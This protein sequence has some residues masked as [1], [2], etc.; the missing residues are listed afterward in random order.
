MQRPTLETER[1]VLRPFVLADAPRVQHL[2]GDRAVAEFTLNIPHPYP[3]GAAEK[4]IASHQPK[5]EKGELVNFAIT[6]RSDGELIGAVGLTLVSAHLRAEIGYWIGKPYWGQGY[7]TEAARAVVRYGFDVLKLNRIQ[8]RHFVG[9]PASGR[10]M[11]K[12]GMIREGCLRQYVRKWGQFVDMVLYGL[13]RSDHHA[14][15]TS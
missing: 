3:D 8:S 1:L 12:L 9:N 15:H 6:L 2:A 4:W 10:V 7:C 11:Q 5:Y 14:S 13:L